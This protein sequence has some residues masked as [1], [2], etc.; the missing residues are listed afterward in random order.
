MASAQ[1]DQSLHCPHEENLG[2]YIPIEHTAKTLIR[3]GGCP[4]WS[5]SSPG[6]QVILLVLSCCSSNVQNRCKAGL[7]YEPHHDK[8][9]LCNMRTTK[10]QISLRIRA[11]WPASAFVSRCLDSIPLISVP[12]ISLASFSCWAGWFGSYLVA[13]SEDRFSRDRCDTISSYLATVYPGSVDLGK[14]PR[15]WPRVLFSWWTYSFCWSAGGAVGTH[16]TTIYQY[17]CNGSKRMIWL[18]L[19][20][21]IVF[22]LYQNNG[23][24]ECNE[25]SSMFGKKTASWL[26]YLNLGPWPSIG[27]PNC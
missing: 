11:V 10:A 7:L 26:Q 2:S 22:Q 8:T 18:F 25:R 24:I 17:A 3:L 9:C 20:S 1:S 6:T 4:G 27:S 15:A 23:M 12:K 14:E 5:E 16:L 19:S 21:S 13:D